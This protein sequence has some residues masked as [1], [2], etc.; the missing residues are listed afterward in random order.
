MYNFKTLL[1]KFWTDIGIYKNILGLSFLFCTCTRYTYMYVW[2]P[3]FYATRA[4]LRAVR[5]QSYWKR[6]CEDERRSQARNAQLVR[7]LERMEANMATL[8]ARREKL[9]L[10]KV[11]L[12]IYMYKPGHWYLS[13]RV[14]ITASSGM[15]WKTISC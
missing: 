7:D 9:R 15:I 8:D 14:K 1:I 5:L 11:S 10:M 12:T 4:K 13:I 3:N 2:P 6:V